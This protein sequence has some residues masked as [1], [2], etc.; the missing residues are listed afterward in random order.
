MKDVSCKTLCF[1]FLLYSY[2]ALLGPPQEFI[3]AHYIVALVL[4]ILLHIGIVWLI[5]MNSRIHNIYNTPFDAVWCLSSYFNRT[6]RAVGICYLGIDNLVIDNEVIHIWKLG[7]Q[8][9]LTVNI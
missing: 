3:L 9:W 6:F 4:C 2:D 7:M 1:L 5:T 8:F